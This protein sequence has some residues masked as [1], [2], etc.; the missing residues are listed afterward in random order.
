MPSNHAWAAVLSA[1][2]R[3]HFRVGSLVAVCNR[4]VQPSR[5]NSAAKVAPGWARLPSHPNTN[6]TLPQPGCGKRAHIVRLFKGTIVATKKSAP[7]NEKKDTPAR[8][9]GVRKSVPQM[10]VAC[11]A[12]LW[13]SQ[14][15]P[16]RPQF[17]GRISVPRFWAP[18]RSGSSFSPSRCRPPEGAHLAEMKRFQA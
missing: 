5:P 15:P 14:W 17:G 16:G 3:K 11:P 1:S 4:I 10:G 12:I 8:E 7:G 2:L 18:A 9:N 13:I 6:A